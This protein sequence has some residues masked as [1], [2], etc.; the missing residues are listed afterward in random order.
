MGMCRN[1]VINFVLCI[2]A[3]LS[4]YLVI[5]K[6]EVRTVSYG[7]RFFLFTCGPS[8]KRVGHKSMGK[9]RGSISYGTDQE[10]KVSKIIII[11]M[12]LIRSR[13]KGTF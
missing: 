3:D 1:L 6:F 2:Y 7:L 5:I 8:T 9:K 10:N 11:S 13:G 4:L 12:K